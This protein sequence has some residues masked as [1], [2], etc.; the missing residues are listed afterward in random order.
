MAY[1]FTAGEKVRFT[2]IAQLGWIANGDE[3]EHTAVTIEDVPNTMQYLN[4]GTDRMVSTRFLVGHDQWLILE[5]GKKYSG[6]FF[7]P[8]N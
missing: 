5:N 6:S 7:E 3:T 8:V 2:K 4:L 1:R